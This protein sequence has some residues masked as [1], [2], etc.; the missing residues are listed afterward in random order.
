MLNFIKERKLKFLLFGTFC[1]IAIFSWSIFVWQDVITKFIADLS[2][3]FRSVVGMLNGVPLIF[4]SL[5]IL[6]LPL[7]FLPV[8]PVYFL[9]SARTDEYSFVVVLLFCLLGVTANIFLSYFLGRKFGT[10]LRSL[11]ARRNIKIPQILPSEEYEL[12]FLMRM[13]PGNPL[14]VQNYGLG[15]A[16]VSLFKYAIVS[17]PIQYIQIVAYI[18]FGEG[19][20]EGGISKIMLASSLLF[21]IA[22]IARILDKRYG[23]KIRKG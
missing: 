9:A 16:N 5:A 17:L 7:F 1:I 19:I 11:L 18:Y 3:Y 2:V 4:Y 8:T 6:I 13:I 21:V 12:I 15:V 20:F 14:S 10:F 22:I 23:Y